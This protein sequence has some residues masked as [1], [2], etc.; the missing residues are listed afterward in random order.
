M[1]R[2]RQKK[3]QK[4]SIVIK[5]YTRKDGKDV[6]ATQISTRVKTNL[7]LFTIQHNL[8]S[9][10]NTDKGEQQNELTKNILLQLA[11]ETD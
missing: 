1:T 3:S 6:S 4:E 9:L 2:Y 10:K 7:E 8:I 11:K 5:L